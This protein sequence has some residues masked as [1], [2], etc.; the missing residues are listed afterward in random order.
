ME[1]VGELKRNA[2]ANKNGISGRFGTEYAML[3]HILNPDDY[4]LQRAGP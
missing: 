2:W 4:C 3:D 1:S